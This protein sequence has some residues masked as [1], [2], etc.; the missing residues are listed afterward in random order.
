[1]ELNI[2]RVHDCLVGKYDGLRQAGH[3]TAMLV[4]LIQSAEMVEGMYVVVVPNRLMVDLTIGKM[5]E[6][7]NH[8]YPDGEL[9]ITRRNGFVQFGNSVIKFISINNIERG[10]RGL[11]IV[12]YFVDITPLTLSSFH[13]A[14]LKSQTRK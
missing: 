13:H 10:I 3:S 8:I 14:L 7:Y 6:I 9:T 1:M 5:E 2:Q 12:N 11:D 4:K